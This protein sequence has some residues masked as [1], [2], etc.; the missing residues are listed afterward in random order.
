MAGNREKHYRIR[1]GKIYARVTF[2]DASGKRRD[3]MRLAESKTQARE[4]AER[5][6]R[7]LNDQGERT[8]D[9]DRMTF[10]ELAEI[11]D[12]KRLIPAIY[13]GERK[14]MGLRSVKAPKIFLRTLVEHFGA[15]RIKEITHSS[16]EK[17][18][19]K[20][21][22]TTTVRGK[23]RSI[24]SVNRE[25][26]ILRACLNFAKREGWISRTAFESGA[27]LVS[28]ADE[29]RRERILTPEEEARLLEACTG[30]REHLRLLLIAAL[31]TAMRHRELIQMKWSDI[32]LENKRIVIRATTTK[33]MRGRT[34]GL[35]ERLANGLSDLFKAESRPEPDARVF[36]ISD[37]VKRSFGGACRDAGVDDLKFHDLRHTAITRWIAQGMP[38]MEVMKLS[39]HTQ[40]DTFARYVNTDDQTARRAAEIMD[41]FHQSRP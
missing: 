33:T 1:N 23:E 38:P 35:T 36:G 12:Q 37:N 31:D 40:W 24:A 30:R 25:L 14:V 21:L 18:R 5:M 10:R 29:V 8:I 4:L 9:G 11:Y 27:S 34:V 26:E 7:E 32:D 16:V 17:Y 19:Q 22:K 15:S 39:G 6:M 2:T 13:Q 3:V 28:K 20:R 41:A